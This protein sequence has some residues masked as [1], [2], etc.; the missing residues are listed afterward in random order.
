VY[1]VSFD[2]Y[3]PSKC[4]SYFCCTLCKC[5]LFCLWFWVHRESHTWKNWISTKFCFRLAKDVTETFQMLSVTFGD[6]TLCKNISFQVI[7]QVTKQ[8]VH[9]WTCWTLER[10]VNKQNRWKCGMNKGIWPSKQKT[11]IWSVYMLGI[12]FGSVKTI[13]KTEH[14]LDFY[15]IHAVL[16]EC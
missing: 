13:W 12:V 15:Q 5:V 3:C 11:H 14:A 9:H 4:G 7:M 16:A 10:L 6:Q 2:F 1:L 8:C